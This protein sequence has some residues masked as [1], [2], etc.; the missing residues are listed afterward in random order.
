MLSLA[1]RFVELD[2]MKDVVKLWLETEFT[3]ED[4]HERRV[5]KIDED[6]Q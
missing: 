6:V 3:G 1:A 4:R 5:K 2:S